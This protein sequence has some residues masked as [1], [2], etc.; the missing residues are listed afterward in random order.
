MP[1]IV[2]QKRQH[3][4]EDR[5]CDHIAMSAAAAEIETG[6][7]PDCSV[8]SIDNFYRL[9]EPVVEDCIEGKLACC[10]AIIDIDRLF[11]VSETHGSGCADHVLSEFGG[12]LLRLTADLYACVAHLG[13]DQFGLLMVGM[14]I[15]TATERLDRLRRE[16]AS[17]PIGWEGEMINITVS[18][19][20][21][22]IQGLETFDNYI[23]AA[24]QFLF[25]AKMSGRNQVISDH[26]FATAVH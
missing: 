24:E 21:A 22:E 3:S 26:T 10:V 1:Y 6:S 14:N 12:N 2:S 9:G 23:N 4:E 13:Q 18:I 20:I 17:C 7:P 11:R 8:L 15:A 25:M 16:L 5:Y 19:G